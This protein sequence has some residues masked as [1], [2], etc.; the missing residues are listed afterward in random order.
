MKDIQYMT[1]AEQVAAFKAS[2]TGAFKMFANIFGVVKILSYV[3][4][5]VVGYFAYVDE[6]SWWW[7]AACAGATVLGGHL[8]KSSAHA[9]LMKQGYDYFGSSV[10]GRNLKTEPTEGS[11]VE[12][13]VDIVSKFGA[14]LEERDYLTKFYDVRELPIEKD[15]ILGAIVTCYNVEKDEGRREML[16]VGILALTHFQT[17]IGERPVETIVDTE[18][19]FADAGN[20][21]L[22]KKGENFTVEEVDETRRLAKSFLEKSD[23]LDKERAAQL[24]ATAEAEYE[25]YIG[26][27]GS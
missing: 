4:Y 27:L 8:A 14:M 3:S 1:Q 12:S 9:H 25:Q 2:P 16:K 23:L 17:N 18:S 6:I 21:D 26:M 10:G 5:V 20:F 11:A 24:S 22:S 19:I 13:A 7:L 15:R